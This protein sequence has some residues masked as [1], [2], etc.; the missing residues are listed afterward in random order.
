[1]RCLSAVSNE[2]DITIYCG[3]QDAPF[4]LSMKLNLSALYMEPT[5]VVHCGHNHWV[6]ATLENTKF[7]SF[8]F[9][10]L[11]GCMDGVIRCFD[12]SGETVGIL[13][14]HKKGVISLCWTDDGRLLSGSWDGIYIGY[15]LNV[16]SY[17]LCQVL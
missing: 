9:V 12:A 6:T 1:V 10:V 13:E 15:K 16:H 17:L 3:G 8:P 5:G 4:F 2:S 14:G 11:S 7:P